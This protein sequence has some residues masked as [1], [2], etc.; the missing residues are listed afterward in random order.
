MVAI[1]VNKPM[2]LLV[3]QNNDGTVAGRLLEE[4]FS[5]REFSLTTLTTDSK[6]LMDCA[7]MVRE[8]PTSCFF[9]EVFAQVPVQSRV[10][11]FKSV[12]ATTKDTDIKANVSEFLSQLD[13]SSVFC[14]K[15]HTLL[16]S[17]TREVTEEKSVYLGDVLDKLNG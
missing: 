9:A 16:F 5:T 11:R 15:L 14:N 4:T 2:L 7:A 8:S 13:N 6:F 12:F 3:Y 17:M 10:Y 1:S